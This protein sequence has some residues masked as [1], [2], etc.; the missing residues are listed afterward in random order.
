MAGCKKGGETEPTE[1]PG[2]SG[3]DTSQTTVVDMNDPTPGDYGKIYYAPVDEAHVAEDDI[4]MYIDNEL[5]IVVKDGVSEEQVRQ[6]AEKY[7][8]EIV[9]AI[10]FTGDY[11]LRLGETLS[12]EG[13]ENTL[14]RI[15]DEDIV[16]SA[17]LNYVA[18]V[19]NNA[20]TAERDG[21][22]FGEEWQN[23]LK[24]AEGL[25]KSWGFEVINT[26]GAWDELNAHKDQV[27]PV[28][29]GLVDG[30]FDISH[31]DLAFAE[32]FYDR[33]ANNRTTNLDSETTKHGTHVAGIMAARCDN[34][35]GICGVY[36]YGAYNLYGVSNGFATPKE[37]LDSVMYLKIAYAELIVRNVK[38]INVSWGFNWYL[39]PNFKG[40][41]DPL[42]NN[43]DY[44]KV[45][46]MMESPSNIQKKAEEGKALGDF[47]ERIL[48]K[49]KYDF[50]IVCAAGNDSNPK[51][52]HIDCQLASWNTLI[53]K[54]DFPNA[55]DRI[56]VVGSVDNTLN[57]AFNSNGGDR[58]DVYAPGGGSSPTDI[59]GDFF[60]GG[61]ARAL[62]RANPDIFS[63]LPGNK[64]GTMS[65]TSQAAPHVAGVAAMVWSANNSL[66]G[67]QVK[68]IIV[69]DANKSTL[70]TS[71][72]MVDAQKAVSD[73]FKEKG[74]GDAAD[75][76]NGIVMSYVVERFHEDN[77]IEK[78][79]I[80]FK[81]SE[82]GEVVYLE[83]PTTGEKVLPETDKEGHFEIALPEGK[84]TLSV[85]ADGY[86]DYEWPDGEDFENPLVVKNGQVKYL[87]SWIKLK[88]ADAT[89]NS[90]APSGENEEPTKADPFAPETETTEETKE[91]TSSNPLAR[92][93]N[94]YIIFGHYEQDNNIENGKEPIEWGILDENA[95][96]K[97]LI[98]RYVL[99]AVPFN[100]EY[101]EVTWETCSLRE[102]LNK[103][104]LNEAFTKDEQVLIPKAHLKNSGIEM[105]G[106]NDTDDQV[107]CLS[108][109]EAAK[110]YKFTYDKYS[111]FGFKKELI[112]LPTEYAKAHGMR[113]FNAK[114]CID[115]PIGDEYWFDGYAPK[116]YQAS[117]ADLAGT[118]WWLR[119]MGWDCDACAVFPNGLAGAHYE[120]GV[121]AE[122][123]GVRPVLWI[124]NEAIKGET[125]TEPNL[126][127]PYDG[128]GVAINAENFPDERF[129]ML[130]QDDYDEDGNWVFS[131]E[132]LEE[133]KKVDVFEENI[134]SLQGIELL[135][136]LQRLQ[137][138][139]NKLTR[140]D[141]S[142]NT[143]LKYLACS[144][145]PLS[146]LDVS[147]NTALEE[148]YYSGTGLKEVDTSKNTNLKV[149]YCSEND[150]THLDVS[151]NPALEALGCK[152]NQLT[153]L[154]VSK[155][156]KLEKLY[157][158]S[159]LLT[160]L[161]LSHNPDLK[162]LH[163]QVNELQTLDVS[164][165]PL[166]VG[167]ECF[168]NQLT[169]LDVSHNPML[170]S[171]DCGSNQ[172]KSFDV[173]H[174]PALTSLT[175]GGNQLES[176]D[177]SHN[178]ELKELRCAANQI[179]NLDLSKNKQLTYL[180]IDKKTGFT[181]LV[182][183][184][185]VELVDGGKFTHMT[186]E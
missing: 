172:L 66:K 101:A 82:T 4:S 28:R 102:W 142:H 100:N 153:S 81:N 9:G 76:Q 46:E 64:Y 75:S 121:S 12:K 167:L 126:P 131:K 158:S 148:L 36:P 98:S 61:A 108:L 94:G 124:S 47:L 73:A 13:L 106:G 52:G 157:C 16:T 51:V 85:K 45:K 156:T 140:L 169:E 58:V 68:E 181:G 173:S 3:S 89:A 163:C 70:C 80:V 110:Y 175:C 69:K 117:I 185:D 42:T 57:M 112:S 24:E 133:I 168:Y 182:P 105:P 60:G 138:G 22:K 116:G 134:S 77:K 141:V 115:G 186:S 174:N 125:E 128:D 31:N 84:Y 103:D 180:R 95:N 183:G 139:K 20:E 130:L 150:M 132:E 8:S 143:K 179:S 166:L 40:G 37:Q 50:V 164:R 122:N 53:R 7:N 71:C 170:T 29:V 30:G 111:Y 136:N 178:E 152:G 43:V 17:S 15:R 6:L 171:I 86:E 59:L 160:E 146:G 165:H 10:E 184:V 56:I 79:K 104:F 25:G 161:D 118:Y 34:S 19:S 149:L 123:Y 97:L 155:N 147:H 88:R 177:V 67:A 33:G 109:D 32:V 63:T 39:F 119:T 162:Q 159:N 44:G 74:T 144:N 5:L 2:K 107:F 114:D 135:Y 145:N 65:G 54:E 21:F 27:K 93:S 129:R 18:P 11:Q 78:A 87:E 113:T 120:S 96:G 48:K 23:D 151:H 38:V 137:C 83:N 176:L 92:E 90:S 35:K 62:L 55:Y 26:L 154:D 41:Y 99:D 14:L 72:H 1:A 91:A 49:N 127:E